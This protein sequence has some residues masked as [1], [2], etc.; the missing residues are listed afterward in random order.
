MP[1]RSGFT[2]IETLGVLVITAV[3][4]TGVWSVTESVT[5]GQ[6]RSMDDADRAAAV[7]SLDAVLRNAVV[8]ATRGTLAAP[9]AGPVHVVVAGSGAT[10]A[11]TLVVLR[12]EWPAMTSSTR[13]CPGGGACLLL[14][15]NDT[16]MA[17]PGDV[18]LVSTPGMGARVYR[19]TSAPGLAPGPCGADC[20]ERVVCAAEVLADSS[21]MVVTRSTHYPRYP[22]VT[23]SIPQGGPCAQAY[24]PVTGW[25]V[26]HRSR[27][28]TPLRRRDCV[29]SG[30]SATYTRVPVDEVTGALRLPDPGDVPRHSG[31]ALTPRVR[32]QRVVPSRF[33]VRRDAARAAPTLV[34]QTGLDLNGAWNPAV[35]VGGPVTALEVETLHPGETA[36][37]RGVGVAAAELVHGPANANYVYAATPADSAAP[38]FAFRRGYHTVGAVRVRFTVPT[39][40][41]DGTTAGVPYTVVVATNGA[42]RGGSEGGW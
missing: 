30:S 15:G 40:R 36:W 9:N 28:R 22:D 32:A 33:F 29:A 13:P 21:V 31:A 4:A 16:A 12:G 27:F 39:P 41:A 34:R 23:D 42:T 11:D 19:V 8:Q 5:R 38:G 10:A 7:A 37:R 2:L 25:C 18:L 35:P 17:R 20:E 3:I 1:G 14:V 24:H 26:E 6:A